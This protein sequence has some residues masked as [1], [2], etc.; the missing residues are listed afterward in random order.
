MIEIEKLYTEYFTPIY[1]FLLSLGA[2][3][4][5]AE[6]LTAQTMFI[7]IN[8]IDSFKNECK[9]SVWLCQ[10][11]KNLYYK[12]LKEDKRFINNE[13]LDYLADSKKEDKNLKELIHQKIHKLEEPYKEVF[14]MRCFADLS[15]KEIAKLFD[16][17][18]SWARVT[19]HRARLRL[20]EELKDEI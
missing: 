4:N 6:E 18:E 17:T 2:S 7:A 16:K 10:I 12:Q 8:K 13:V 20:N 3:K 9:L 11:A 19:Y 5:L 14:W 15:F 1:R